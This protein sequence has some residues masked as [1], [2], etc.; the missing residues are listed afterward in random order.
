[1]SRILIADP[2]R[3]SQQTGGDAS[4]ERRKLPPLVKP[5]QEMK[6]SSYVTNLGGVYS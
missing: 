6:L 2:D 3:S 5:M 1:M 4:T